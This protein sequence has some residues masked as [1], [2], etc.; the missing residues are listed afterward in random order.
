[1][2]EQ[3][4]E[5]KIFCVGC[6]VKD[7]LWIG[8]FCL[9]ATMYFAFRVLKG[10]MSRRH[11]KEKG[12]APRS[13]IQWW[14]DGTSTLGKEAKSTGKRPK[15]PSQDLYKWMKTLSKNMMKKEKRKEDLIPP[16]QHPGCTVYWRPPLYV[17]KKKEN[18]SRCQQQNPRFLPTFS[19]STTEEEGLRWK[20]TLSAQQKPWGVP[21]LHRK[22]A[23]EDIFQ[24]KNAIYAQKP[25]LGPE[26]ARKTALKE[27]FQ[28]KREVSAPKL[29]IAPGF[30]KNQA[31]EEAIR[32]Q[33]AIDAEIQKRQ[34][35]ER[36]P[37]PQRKTQGQRVL[38]EFD[39]LEPP[40]MEVSGQGIG[41]AKQEE[42]LDQLAPEGNLGGPSAQ[43]AGIPVP[44]TEEPTGPEEEAG[45]PNAEGEAQTEDPMAQLI[46]AVS[47]WEE[48]VMT[49]LSAMEA[50][51]AGHRQ[52]TR[53]LYRDVRALRGQ[54]ERMPEINMDI[55]I[56][57]NCMEILSQ[58]MGAL[59]KGI[60]GAEPSLDEV[61]VMEEEKH[62]WWK[63]GRKFRGGS[64][65]RVVGEDVRLG[66]PRWNS[67][68]MQM[69]YILPGTAFLEAHTLQS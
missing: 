42:Q 1:M 16:S 52:A 25:V 18:A 43:D 41:A 58:L 49:Q 3:V 22:K 40:S 20:N 54:L 6:V 32:T 64:K 39:L 14:V 50:H 44:A 29:W 7:F 26:I 2:A 46:S 62:T 48:R 51:M 61:L 21:N 57:H 10:L 24:R 9:T 12:L 23:D 55:R 37:S 35:Q 15:R 67:W 34:K 45:G 8:L 59:L 60:L 38:E 13:Q 66:S 47:S 5:G 17:T 65:G 11:K 36:L 4:E 63:G 68:E 31:K 56:V 27:L 19:G 33:K 28:R 30:E 53:A 69:E